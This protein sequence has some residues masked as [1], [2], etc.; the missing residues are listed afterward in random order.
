MIWAVV[1]SSSSPGVSCAERLEPPPPKTFPRSHPISRNGHKPMLWEKERSQPRLL[2]Q[3]PRYIR[4][5][6]VK[7]LDTGAVVTS[8]AKRIILYILR[9]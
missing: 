3:V 6:L 7:M 4:D 9:D 1:Q 5:F 2:G 8:L